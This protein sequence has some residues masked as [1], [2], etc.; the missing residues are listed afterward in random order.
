MWTNIQCWCIFYE[1]TKIMSPLKVIMQSWILV[2]I[3]SIYMA[4]FKKTIKWQWISAFLFLECTYR[5]GADFVHGKC[6]WVH[7]CRRRTWVIR[8][9]PI[10]GSFS[11]THQLLHSTGGQT[12]STSTCPDPGMTNPEK[13]SHMLDKPH[14]SHEWFTVSS[15]AS[16]WSSNV[17]PG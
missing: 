15:F 14:V 5:T 16:I 17:K 13:L 6:L 7:R 3:G 1:I 12:I 11:C 10:L 8:A 4:P 9:G 2:I